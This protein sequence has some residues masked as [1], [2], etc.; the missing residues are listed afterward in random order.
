MNATTPT[1]LSVDFP[2]PDIAMTSLSSLDQYVISRCL[3]G[4]DMSECLGRGTL[5]SIAER[6]GEVPAVDIL[7][8]YSPERVAELRGRLGLKQGCMLDIR[9]AFV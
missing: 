2:D 8:M 6:V 5:S 7:E 3:L 9:N 1:S 4:A